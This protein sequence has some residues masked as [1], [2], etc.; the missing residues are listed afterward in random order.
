MIELLVYII[1]AIVIA[2]II[3]YTR[4]DFRCFNNKQQIF[5]TNIFAW[6]MILYALL[7][8]FIP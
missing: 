8:T 4:R 7:T 1:V 6:F 3:F 2:V 5:Y